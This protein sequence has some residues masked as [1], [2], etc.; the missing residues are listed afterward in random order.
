MAKSG[1]EKGAREYAK[2][3][4]K[5]LST[6]LSRIVGDRK[7]QIT[8]LFIVS[9]I[10]LAFILYFSPFPSSKRIKVGTL[11]KRDILASRKIMVDDIRATAYQRSEALKKVYPVFNYNPAQVDALEDNIRRSF[12]YMRDYF[13]DLLSLSS[14]TSLKKESPQSEKVLL[15]RRRLKLLLRE[16]SKRRQAFEKI[17]GIHLKDSEYELLKKYRFSPV[18]EKKLIQLI[19]FCR[20]HWVISSRGDF[21][22]KDIEGLILYNVVTHKDTVIHDIDLIFDLEDIRGLFMSRSREVLR[23]LPPPERFL[24]LSMAQQIIKPNVVFAKEVTR[25][26]IKKAME[27]V[28]PV[29]KEIRKGDVIIHKGERVT[30]EQMERLRVMEQGKTWVWRATVFLGFLLMTFFIIFLPYDFSVKNIRKVRFETRDLVF[31][32]ILLVLFPLA[33]K[34]YSYISFALKA[35]FPFLSSKTLL[36]LFPIA[37]AGMFVRIALNSEV[38][39]I[40]SIILSILFSVIVDSSAS[41]GIIAFL[42]N[43]LGA[44]LVSQC[45]KRSRVLWAGLAS[46]ILGGVLIAT[47]RMIQGTFLSY[48]TGWGVLFSIVG[49]FISGILVLGFTPLLEALFGYTTDVKLLELANL[50]HPLLKEMILKAPGTY[51]H[52]IMV[53][54][55]AEAAAKDI[56]ADPVLVR[57]GA[58]YHDIGKIKKPLYFIENQQ[59]GVNK[60]DKLS[61]SMSSLILISHVKEGIE[62]ARTFHLGKEIIDIIQQH[63]GTSLIR[64]FYNKAVE[65]AGDDADKIDE[66]VFRYPG[67]RPQ[68]REAGLIMLADAVE[69]TA[70]S[71]NSPTPAR[72][73]TIIQDTFNRIFLDGQLDEC[74]L[75]LKNL[76][77]IADRFR[78]VLMAVFHH[79]IDYPAEGKEQKKEK[80][81]KWPMYGQKTGR[82][83]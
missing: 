66:D 19:R 67:P 75:T 57:V 20:N 6:T 7:V 34:F 8:S 17:L 31:L 38:A 3:D 79:R 16:E 45:E 21:P 23:G 73:N 33:L 70:R 46:G 63:H 25:Q 58:Y 13:E 60:H 40:F 64:F 36:F 78:I 49:G 53:A 4:L 44:E 35:L 41:F 18:V 72:I 59:G 76:H 27:S 68:T 1:N 61:P 15:K 77:Q 80:G 26:H 11:A 54:S 32:G 28:R 69:A 48:I 22:S 83:V 14:E 82:A 51:H 30:A 65:A 52:S 56:G 81:E 74:E 9:V 50:D 5:T 12:G 71:L 10:S 43:I 39:L 37:A 2:G 62:L 47:N 55:L 24:I 29:V 42:M